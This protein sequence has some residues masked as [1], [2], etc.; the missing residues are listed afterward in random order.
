MFGIGLPELILIL[1]IAL[2]VVGPEKLPEM[3]KALGKGIAELKKAASTLKESFE[4]GEEEKKHPAWERQN[5][6]Q[7]PQKLLDAF[8]NLPKEAMVEKPE[9]PDTREA[10]PDAGSSASTEEIS[11][12]EAAAPESAEKDNEQ[13]DN[14]S[15]S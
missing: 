9:S 6:E 3:A 15:N 1:A 2:I 12:S 10:K 11:H 4:E 13:E 7:P 5:P 8:D 14:K